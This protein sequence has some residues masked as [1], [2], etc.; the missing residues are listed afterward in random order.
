MKEQNNAIVSDVALN[1]DRIPHAPSVARYTRIAVTLHWIVALLLVGSYSSV[2]FRHWFTQKATPASISALEVHIACGISIGVFVVLRIAWRL[3][4][5]PPALPAGPRWQLLAAR[6]S[7]GLLYV[8]MVAQP[9][10]GY[11]ATRRP[12]AYLSFVPPFPNSAMYRWLVTDTLG[13]SW[14]TWAKSLYFVHDITGSYLLWLLVLI[15]AAVALYHQFGR[16][17]G[18]MRRMWF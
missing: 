15:H 16:R 1:G 11:G 14:S 6:I 4:N 3:M 10:S 13:I 17:D 18:L 12:S 8:L 7:H 5:Q 2:Y 9:L